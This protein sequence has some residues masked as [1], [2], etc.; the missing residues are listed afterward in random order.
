MKYR[1]NRQKPRW[2][3]AE[4]K[5]LKELVAAHGRNWDR[6]ALRMGNHRTSEGYRKRI[7]LLAERG[8]LILPPTEPGKVGVIRRKRPPAL[9]AL[10]TLSVQEVQKE[11][12]APKT[13]VLNGKSTSG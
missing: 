2:T 5:Q 13:I 7:Y 9:E 6:I 1:D 4:E 11:A 10:P 3:S 8:E 12:D